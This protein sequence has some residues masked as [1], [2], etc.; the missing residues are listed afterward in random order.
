MILFGWS[1]DFHEFEFKFKIF[2]EIILLKKLLFA[3]QK[4]MEKN[5]K[6]RF[7]ISLNWPYFD[8]LLNLS[9]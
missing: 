4:I 1:K 8:I 9:G 6:I 5:I 2:I 3:R 7:E